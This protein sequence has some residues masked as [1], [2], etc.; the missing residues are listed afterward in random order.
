VLL[1]FGFSGGQLLTFFL[2][3][4][5]YFFLTV[6]TAQPANSFAAKFNDV[7]REVTTFVRPGVFYSQTR[8]CAVRLEEQEAAG[9]MSDGLVRV[10]ESLNAEAALVFRI[11][12]LRPAKELARVVISTSTATEMI[13]SD[14]LGHQVLKLK[15]VNEN[16][17]FEVSLLSRK[18]SHDLM[19]MSVRSGANHG[20]CY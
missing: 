6:A 18:K 15:G 3:N 2:L 20:Y 8:N 16:G 12:Q 5:S 17:T 13:R 19:R 4:F 7:Q 10:T 14:L 9:S 1:A 11:L